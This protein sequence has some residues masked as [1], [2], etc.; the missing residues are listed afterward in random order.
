MSSERAELRLRIEDTGS[1]FMV[2]GR[3]VLDQG[4]QKIP[5]EADLYLGTG[6]SLAEAVQIAGLFGTAAAGAIDKLAKDR[7]MLDPQQTPPA[8]IFSVS[9]QATAIEAAQP[10]GAQLARTERALRELV[11]TMAAISGVEREQAERAI[12]ELLNTPGDIRAQAEKVADTYLAM[13]KANI[14]PSSP[15]VTDEVLGSWKDHD[16]NNPY[17]SCT[18]CR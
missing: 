8:A 14:G 9:S 7:S 16:P 4:A 17:C 1:R 6:D 13:R 3:W 18:K 11:D 12:F 10:T 15:D 2:T 5:Y